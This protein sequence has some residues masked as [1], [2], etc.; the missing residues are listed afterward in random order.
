M[1]DISLS[2]I[3]TLDR[4]S[5]IN[6]NFDTIESVINSQ[7]LHTQGGNNV[8]SQALD[9]NGRR[10]LN[11]PAPTSPTDLVRLQDLESIVVDGYTDASLITYTAQGT[12]AEVT[13]VQDRI[14]E[15][16]RSPTDFGAVFDGV[17]DDTAAWVACEAAIYAAGGGKL[18]VPEGHSIVSEV[19]TIRSNI[20]VEG[21]GYSSV[22]EQTSA[23]SRVFENLN[24]NDGVLGGS[25]I[26]ENISF[27]N[28]RVIN[29]MADSTSEFAHCVQFCYVRNLVVENIW[30]EGAKGDGLYLGHNQQYR[31]DNVRVS[32]CDRQGVTIQSGIGGAV[33]GIY[34]INYNTNA[35]LDIEP[36]TGAT[37]VG[38]SVKNVKLLSG[39]GKTLN[40]Y[41]QYSPP[42]IYD[43]HIENVD[44][45]GGLIVTGIT[46]SKLSNINITHSTGR[47]LEMYACY[48]V[49][50]DNI[51]IR[52]TYDAAKVYLASSSDLNFSNIDIDGPGGSSNVSFDVNDACGRVYV[53]GLNISSGGVY[54]IRV[55][56]SQD[57][58]IANARVAGT[59]S[60]GAIVAH[61]SGTS[62][63]ITFRNITFSGVTTGVRVD[64]GTVGNVY[65]HDIRGATTNISLGSFTGLVHGAP[66]SFTPTLYGSGTA[67][68]QVYTT[69]V[70]TYHIVDKMCYYQVAITLSTRDAAATGE[71]LIGGF[72]SALAA[73]AVGSA[74]HSCAI[75]EWG[76]IT[77]PASAT[78]IGAHVAAGAQYIRLRASGA[79]VAVQNL[80][81]ATHIANTTSIVLSGCI[82]LAN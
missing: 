41:G 43:L 35:L 73:L 52:G 22:V 82:M 11:V 47:A 53:N 44:A 17:T 39:S 7:I 65:L 34:G 18:L 10:V 5:S 9:M 14:R 28:L 77:L 48:G 55:R 3:N 62:N 2:P 63:N 29:N 80:S 51:D 8:M 74:H 72:P 6:D 25:I 42:Q 69:Q 71:P 76:N 13:N 58:E 15:F 40:I 78:S 67:G 79:G 21:Q 27:K 56:N 45:A 36:D 57:V 60:Y 32:N 12:G 81:I 50:I 1:A 38:L 24:H 61:T 59:S 46:R 37:V 16:G 54:G 30:V 31:I 26:D 49:D 33:N 23:N 70:G 66:V 68:T 75:S 4:L 19:I 64:S 20:C